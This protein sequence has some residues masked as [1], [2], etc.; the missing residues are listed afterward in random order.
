MATHKLGFL[1]INTSED[2]LAFRIGEGRI[3]RFGLGK[4]NQPA[5]EGAY[6][7]DVY[8]DDGFVDDAY[9]TDDAVVASGYTGRFAQPAGRGS[10]YDAYD[11]YEDDYADDGYDDGYDDDYADDGYADDGYDDGYADDGYG[12]DGYDDGG[13]YGD[14]GYYDDGYEDRYSD[15]DASDYGGY[16]EYGSENPVLRYID[17]NDWVTYVLLFLLPPLGIYLLWR[18]RRFENPIRW[19]ISAISGV[20]FVILLILLISAILSG[21]GD[22]TRNPPITMTTPTPT[23]QTEVEVTPEATGSLLDDVV[24]NPATVVGSEGIS[25]AQTV[26]A[27]APDATPTPLPGYNAVQSNAAGYVTVTAT[28]PYYHNNSSCPELGSGT[29]SIVTETLAVQRNKA[30]CPT[31]YPGQELYYATAGGNYYHLDPTCSGMKN[32]V[33]ITKAAAEGRGQKPC[34]VCIK[35]EVN[36]LSKTGLKYIDGTYKDKSGITVYATSKGRYFHTDSSCSGMKNATSGTLLQAKV[37][38]KAACPTCANGADTLVWFTKGGERYHSKSNCSGM[39]GANQ[40]TLAEA[41]IMGKARCTTCISTAPAFGSGIKT[42]GS[43][44]YVY[45]T[46]TGDYYHTKSDCSGMK[47]AKRVPLATML[48]TNRKACP[49]CA[50]SA[51][52]V[53]YAT[54]DGAYFHSYATCSGMKNA[55]SGTMAQAMALGKV[56][57]PVC[58]SSNGKAVTTGATASSTG[59]MVYAT[60]EGTY[61]HTNSSCSGMK[62]ASRI[63]LAVA[64]RY[65]KVACPTCAS[66][67]TRSVY[68][69]NSGDYYHVKSDCSGMKKA[70][71]RTLQDALL[72]GQSSCPVCIGNNSTTSSKKPGNTTNTVSNVQQH[73]ISASGTYQAG[74]SGVKVYATASDKHYHAYKQHAG[75]GAIKVSLETAMNYNKTACPTCMKAAATTVYAVRGGRYYHTSKKC[76]GTG[77]VSGKLDAALAYGLDACPVCVT[78][79]KKVTNSNTYKSGKSG[80]KVWSTMSGKYFH[81]SKSCAGAGASQVTLEVALNYG[82]TA[83]P[84]CAASASKT[85]YSTGSDKYYHS[86]RKHA[87]KNSASGTW[88]VALA[89]GKKACPVCIGGSE[90]VEESDIKYSAAADTMV[91]IDTGSTMFYYHK[92]NRCSDAGFS[93]GTGVSLEFVVGWGFH[94]CPYCNPPTSVK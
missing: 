87:G 36:T 66:A 22:A 90:A 45:A 64:V 44:V 82:K 54:G 65:G 81:T 24:N 79:T 93:G 5:L 9:E 46:E 35:G 61:Y 55:A 51:N 72:L 21:P 70:T 26:D 23:A 50:S 8:A 89:M 38:G 42:N 30:P 48:Q 73:T 43:A 91:Y 1:K 53:V 6:D 58:W 34:P 12:D 59:T 47:G 60:Q 78:R 3:H 80:L 94:A 63:D 14:G 57:C 27:L 32:A 29:T 62:N 17:E 37:A 92:G 39:Q 33:G 88:A 49:V 40:A 71:K 41:L 56:Q 67:A 31:C 20:W 76:A 28:G 68:S 11:A 19:A 4:K 16:E 77:A 15:E 2:G 18:R 13:D 84:N 83:C 86:S 74:S 7:S 10:N 25:P 75:S 85:V 52:T 69:T